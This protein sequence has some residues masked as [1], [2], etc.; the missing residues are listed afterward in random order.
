MHPVRIRI[1][2]FFVPNRLVWPESE[3][4][5]WENFITGGKDGTNSQQPPGVV[6][7][8][9]KKSLATYLGNPP[10]QTARRINAMPIRA[11]NLIY[12][13]YY[14]DQDLAPE[15][16]MN[17]PDIKNIAWEKD[18]F[19]TA[20]PWAQKGPQITL[21]LGTKADVT[22]D[23]EGL[24]GVKGPDGNLNLKAE[25]SGEGR[26]QA[27][28][29]GN[30]PDDAR[31]LYADL[32]SASQVDINAFRAGFALQRYQEARSRYGSRFTEYLRYLGVTPSDARL[33]RP[34]FLGG[35]S[36]RLNFS[37]VLQTSKN[38]GEETG[39]GDLFG[40]GIAGM[41]TN[42]FRKF[43]EEH[44]YVISFFSARPKA[45]YLNGTHREFLKTTKEDYFQRELANLGQQE[46]RQGE[47][48]LDSDNFDTGTFGWADR[49]DE[50]R[51]HP[52]FI[53][54]D[55]RD[56]LKS[57]HFGRDL[58][59]NVALNQSFIECRPTGNPFQVPPETADTLWCMF[60]HHVVARRMVPKKAN[61]RIL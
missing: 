38:S 32:A 8:T 28:S 3:N 40:H 2:H 14:R 20:R 58:P 27:L 9:T 51:T 11:A 12:N 13:E 35:G 1:H 47:V 21:P 36:T 44:G 33:Q 52:S 26:M 24:T 22:V 54:Q 31:L 59:Q 53:G 18:Y 19:T 23:Q 37:E 42:A 50:Y 30:V 55:F 60:N 16:S 7:S 48:Y 56:T 17:A 5:G 43:F 46:V 57:W 45:I 49:Y 4:E 15:A 29:G 6:T 10:T 61:P 34:E 25:S 39:V 41:R